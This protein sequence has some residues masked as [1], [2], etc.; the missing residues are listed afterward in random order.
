MSA[1]ARHVGAGF[2]VLA[3]LLGGLARAAGNPPVA[4]DD[5]G[6][7]IRGYDAVAYFT[8]GQARKGDPTI[9]YEWM[10]ATWLF[11]SAAHRD[12][13]AADPEAYAPQFGGYC[14]Y[15][16]AQDHVAKADPEVWRIVDGKLYLNLGPG[17]QSQWE[18]DIPGF[19]ARANG[20]W[21]GALVDPGLR[22]QIAPAGGG[23]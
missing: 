8:D 1:F 12:A 23:N 3:L 19:I 14:A 21:P 20:N 13:F 18:K 9:A 15:A 6:L 17:V 7:A 2:V 22:R 16:V 4:I 10:D 11:A 5:A